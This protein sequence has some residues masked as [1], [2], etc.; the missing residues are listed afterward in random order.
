MA[1]SQYGS[2]PIWQGAR[3]RVGS[4]VREWEE[5]R[6]L[7]LDDSFEHEAWNPA[8]EARIVLLV[9]VWHPELRED[10]RETVR[11]HFRFGET[12]WWTLHSPWGRGVLSR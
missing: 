5:G 4:E 6:V 10:E 12:S 2:L 3:I 1:A 8:D 11:E 7:I 9:D